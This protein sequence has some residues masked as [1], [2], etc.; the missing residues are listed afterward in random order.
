[1]D[2][3]LGTRAERR[4]G[5]PPT[6]QPMSACGRWHAEPVTVEDKLALRERRLLGR[7]LYGTIIFVLL[8]VALYVWVGLTVGSSGHAA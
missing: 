8:L 3:S 2:A 4:F 7:A 1:V 5:S 6:A